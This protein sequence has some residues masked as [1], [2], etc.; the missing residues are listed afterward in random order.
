MELNE[1]EIELLN[2]Y[3]EDSEDYSGDDFP[4]YEANESLAEQEL[5]MNEIVQQGK[6]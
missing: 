2:G 1:S 5:K 6:P 3:G 4:P